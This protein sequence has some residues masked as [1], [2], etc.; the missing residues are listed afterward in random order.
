[1]G[2]LHVLPTLWVIFIFTLMF[3]GALGVWQ[4]LNSLKAINLPLAGVSPLVGC[5]GVHQK[6]A[7]SIPGLGTCQD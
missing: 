7:G 6:F 5:C 4:I 2:N 3:Q 1:M